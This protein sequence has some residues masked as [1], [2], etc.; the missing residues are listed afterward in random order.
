MNRI[1]KKPENCFLFLNPV[2]P[3][4]LGPLILLFTL[5]HYRRLKA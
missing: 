3:V 4:N 5:N 1:N 2:N